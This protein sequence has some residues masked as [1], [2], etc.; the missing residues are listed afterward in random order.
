M[1]L[2]RQKPVLS[3]NFKSEKQKYRYKMDIKVSYFFE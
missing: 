1:K 3:I 2:T